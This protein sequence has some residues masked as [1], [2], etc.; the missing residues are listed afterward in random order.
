[1]SLTRWLFSPVSVRDHIIGYVLTMA[2][3]LIV[4][5][6]FNATMHVSEGVNFAITIVGIVI[7]SAR[8]LRPLVGLMRK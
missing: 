1:M 5:V 6:L 4:V 8:Y 7:L 3:L 2:L